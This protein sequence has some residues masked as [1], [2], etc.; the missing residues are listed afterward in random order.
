VP[1]TVGV[2]FWRVMVVTQP[3]T[4]GANT[5]RTVGPALDT[6]LTYRMLGSWGYSQ[7]RTTTAMLVA[8]VE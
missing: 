5:V 4:A 2:P 6:G 7:S 1:V 8:G 3:A